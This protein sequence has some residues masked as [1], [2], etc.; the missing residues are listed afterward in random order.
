[1]K[2]KYLWLTFVVTLF[3][4]V[5]L[6]V[7]QLLFLTDERGFYTDGDMIAWVLM[8]LLFTAAAVL[9][10]GSLTSRCLPKRFTQMR[11]IPSGVIHCGLGAAAI[12]Y[13]ILEIMG[14]A[15]PSGSGTAGGLL[16]VAII[17]AFVGVGAGVVWLMNGVSCFIGKNLLR[18]IPTAGI[19]PPIWLAIL[20][21]SKAVQF[22]GTVV[23]L[24]NTE[25]MYDTMTLI[26]MMLF[27]FNHAKMIAGAQGKKCGKRVYGYGL[28][29]AL[30]GVISALPSFIA[31]VPGR[32][33]VGSLGLVMSIV[34]ATLSLTAVVFL[35]VLPKGDQAF[36]EELV[37]ETPE[38]EAPADGAATPVPAEQEGPKENLFFRI[39]RSILTAIANLRKKERKKKRKVIPWEAGELDEQ[40]TKQMDQT[41]RL[42]F[43]G[44][45]SDDEKPYY[46]EITDLDPTAMD[47]RKA[48]T[49]AGQAAIAAEEA[50]QANT[51][52]KKYR[53]K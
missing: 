47:K 36:V 39:M 18:W 7:Y 15:R 38:E 48:R 40:P 4:A 49:E 2:S 51:R 25:Y 37:E 32:G 10:V 46:P 16:Y 6:R 28:T 24:N 11:N 12:V 26:W 45:D 17:L 33:D 53:E 5:P 41:W 31:L 8:G 3:L 29:M 9:I 13:S 20:V 21:F 1:M 50:E 52:K 14:L 44:I 34:V 22:S 27:V 42:D 43:Y 35:I 19:L 23:T 30:F